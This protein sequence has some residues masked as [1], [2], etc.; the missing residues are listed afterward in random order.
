[1][2]YLFWQFWEKLNF[3]RITIRCSLAKTSLSMVM[4][5]VWILDHFIAINNFCSD[6]GTASF[7][8]SSDSIMN[9]RRTFPTYIRYRTLVILSI[10]ISIAYKSSKPLFIDIYIS[11]CCVFWK[12]N[13][14]V[15]LIKWIS[16]TQ[17]FIKHF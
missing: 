10:T 12:E 6:T 5:Y 16:I 11:K 17:H 4:S 1:M 2:M 3:I 7:S 13:Q 8:L 15:T 9:V 14:T